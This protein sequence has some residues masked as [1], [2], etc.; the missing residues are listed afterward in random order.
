[1]SWLDSTGPAHLSDGLSVV[2]RCFFLPTPRATLRLSFPAASLRRSRHGV[3][4]G[5][6]AQAGPTRAPDWLAGL[7]H[8]WQFSFVTPMEGRWLSLHAQHHS[9]ALPSP[10]T[11]T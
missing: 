8:P 10:F 6:R 11:C 1:M 2:L 5:E 9:C 4:R 3:G 7:G